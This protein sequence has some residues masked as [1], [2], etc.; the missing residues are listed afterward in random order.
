MKILLMGDASGCHATLA[1]ALQAMG[2]D[3]TVAS[4]G[5]YWMNTR[6][7]IDIGRREGKLGGAILW[8]R[9]NTILASSLRGYD[10][11]SLAGCGFLDLRPKRILKMFNRL[12]SKNGAIFLTDLA[13]STP[14]V[15]LCTD[16]R[17]QIPYSEWR[18]PD[19]TATKYSQIA[20][21]IYR[22]WTG[23]LAPMCEAIYSNV[24]GVVSVLYEYHLAAQRIV[25]PSR[26]A[27]GGIPIDTASI[28]YADNILRD[29]KVRLF[30]GMHRAR[31]LEKGS[32]RLSWIV[33]EVIR[34]EPGRFV[35]D[36]VENRPIDEYLRLLGAANIVF[37]QFY[38]L[39]PATNALQAMAM[40]KV[41]VSGGE[42]SYYDFIGEK[43]L[44]PIIN[45]IPG[46]EEDVVRQILAIGDDPSLLTS[47]GRQGREL[48]E[49][50][51][52]AMVVAKRFIDFW[53]SRL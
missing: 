5:N 6:R 10:V 34:R 38:S 15:E 50:H 37:D 31:A 20:D 29:G 8:L 25:E 46:R 49:R 42:E 22:A 11:V 1:R 51:N 45:P 12:K 28:K 27:Y 39:T 36:Y 2:H 19:G 14:F 7:N 17:R 3:V 35:F 13:T 23:P 24:D 40:G 32:D 33:N 44:R 18:N 53:Q 52:D 48:T 30:M 47:M 43:D 9:L 26:L 41:A 4:T 21:D 16:S